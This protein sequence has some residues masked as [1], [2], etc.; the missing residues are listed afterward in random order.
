MLVDLLAAFSFVT[1][2][3]DIHAFDAHFNGIYSAFSEVLGT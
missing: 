1:L 2:D 3:S